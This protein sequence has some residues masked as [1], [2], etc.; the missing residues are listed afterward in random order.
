MIPDRKVLTLAQRALAT[1]D[2]KPLVQE[3]KARA[4]KRAKQ[5][6]NLAKKKE[7]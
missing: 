4:L 5:R 7:Q 3:L 2:D 6:H 1:G